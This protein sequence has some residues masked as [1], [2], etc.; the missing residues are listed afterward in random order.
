MYH[1]CI[2]S[3]VRGLFFGSILKQVVKLL[4]AAGSVIKTGSNLK[5]VHLKQ[6]LPC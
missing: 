2:Q 1:G 3:E 5:P 4:K 6:I